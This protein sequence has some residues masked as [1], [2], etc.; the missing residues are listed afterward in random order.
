MKKLSLRLENMLD[1]I[2]SSTHTLVDV[3]ADH[4]YLILEAIDRKKI[5][6]GLAIE[7]KQGPY[8][9]LCS[10]IKQY[11]YEKEIQASFSSGLEKV[12]KTY[13]LI[14]IAGMG[15][16]SIIKIL[17]EGFMHLPCPKYL[18]LDAHNDLPLLRREV[19]SLGYHI[20]EERIL[21]EDNVFYELILFSLGKKEY[22]EEDYL[23]GPCL[24][25]EKSPT[26]L[27]KWQRKIEKY[28]E[29]LEKQNISEER[30]KELLLEI[31]RIQQVL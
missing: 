6:G 7:N 1:M 15:A 29:I 20:D 10:S 4:G 12:E 14:V 9:H 30:K 26:F 13:D 2:P 28:K 17:K 23:F 8:E 27:L 25:K 21:E 22:P 19:V 16:G 5:I 11:G 18:L 3:G 24:R 31:E